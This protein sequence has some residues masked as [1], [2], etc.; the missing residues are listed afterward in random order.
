MTLQIPPFT[1]AEA[2]SGPVTTDLALLHE[3]YTLFNYILPAPIE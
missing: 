2:V 1:V 3:T